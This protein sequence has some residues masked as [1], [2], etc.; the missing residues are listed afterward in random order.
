M[1]WQPLKEPA[2]TV[3]LKTSSAAVVV[4]ILISH[5]QNIALMRAVDNDR[6]AGVEMHS[7]MQE[8]HSDSL[9]VKPAST[10]Q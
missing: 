6:I 8:I 10:W 9:S 1:C 2:A 4:K 5:Q 7:F 3:M